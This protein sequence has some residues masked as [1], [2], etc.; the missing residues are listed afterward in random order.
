VSLDKKII[1]SEGDCYKNEN[2]MDTNPQMHGVLTSGMYCENRCRVT[3]GD[4]GILQ[5]HEMLQI[6]CSPEE[7]VTI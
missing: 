7:I 6:K 3:A 4:H 2:F 1:Q 5:L